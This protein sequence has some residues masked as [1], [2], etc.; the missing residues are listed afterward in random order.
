MLSLSVMNAGELEALKPGL[1]NY[2]GQKRIALAIEQFLR[3]HRMDSGADEDLIFL[4]GRSL[5]KA[6][7]WE[8]LPPDVL[9]PHVKGID[10]ELLRHFLS[11]SQDYLSRVSQ[12]SEASNREEKRL[13]VRQ[14]GRVRYRSAPSSASKGSAVSAAAPGQLS[15]GKILTVV[16]AWKR[17]LALEQQQNNKGSIVTSTLNEGAAYLNDDV[18]QTVVMGKTN[19][20]VVE[21]AGSLLSQQSKAKRTRRQFLSARQK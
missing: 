12:L 3:S 9:A 21:R 19:K 18:A 15:K 2:D 13:A 17:Q 4:T 11:F 10:R 1:E 16:R 5:T 20:R 7:V 8:M 6:G 14:Q